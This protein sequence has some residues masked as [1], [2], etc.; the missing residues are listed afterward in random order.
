MKVSG[1]RPV[2]TRGDPYGEDREAGALISIWWGS[3]LLTR[4]VSSSRPL[5][6]KYV[7]LETGDAPTPP[8]TTRGANPAPRL[9]EI[10][11]G[12]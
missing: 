2:I 3:L 5:S 11:I 4:S 9:A 10:Q 7:I 1:Y 8:P 12:R 6:E